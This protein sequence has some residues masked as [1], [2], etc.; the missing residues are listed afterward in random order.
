MYVPRIDIFYSFTACIYNS[1]QSEGSDEKVLQLRERKD[2]NTPLLLITQHMWLFSLNSCTVFSNFSSLCL[3]NSPITFPSAISK[4]YSRKLRVC[5]SSTNGTSIMWTSLN[6]L[7]QSP[8]ILFL[9]EAKMFKVSSS[10]RSYPCNKRARA[11]KRH[12]LSLCGCLKFSSKLRHLIVQF[13]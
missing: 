3:A 8:S 12:R 7:G 10:R 6:C 5:R 2:W 9:D 1:L 13:F 11:R 4:S